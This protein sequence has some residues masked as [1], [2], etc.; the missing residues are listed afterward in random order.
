MFNPYRLALLCLIG[1]PGCIS[2]QLQAPVAPPQ[3]TIASAQ[4]LQLVKEG[5][6]HPTYQWGPYRMTDVDTGWRTQ[7]SGTLLEL[8]DTSGSGLRVAQKFSFTLS[9]AAE[10]IQ[11]AANF[12][13][14]RRE[15]DSAI[16][17][18][19]VADSQGQDAADP[20]GD[21]CEG[22]L[23]QGA[24]T[25]S[26]HFDL[27]RTISQGNYS[28]G[29]LLN[30]QGGTDLALELFTDDV[31]DFTAMRQVTFRQGKQIIAQ[32]NLYDDNAPLT[33]QQD[34]PAATR[35]Q[36]VA[37]AFLMVLFAQFQESVTEAL[38]HPST[39]TE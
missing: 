16:H 21:R 8:F 11:V 38:D 32:L 28:S 10:T 30:E 3:V 20:Y 22:H 4:T 39:P 12:S 33:L 5:I 14:R 18:T 13:S 26:W 24:S 7:T 1:C 2:I 35:R 36:V 37:M 17:F 31:S 23:Y 6:W 29:A 19:P 15:D 9:E 34:L 25:N 27:R